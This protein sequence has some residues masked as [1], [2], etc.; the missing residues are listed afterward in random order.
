MQATARSSGTSPLLSPGSHGRSDSLFSIDLRGGPA[1]AGPAAA[2]ATH[3]PARTGQAAPAVA[4]EV[5]IDVPGDAPPPLREQIEAG[6]CRLAFKAPPGPLREAQQ[7]LEHEYVDWAEGV[8]NKRAAAFG[9]GAYSIAQGQRTAFGEAVVPALYDAARQFVSSSSRS[10]VQGATQVGLAPNLRN[11]NGVRVNHGELDSHVDA[12][13]IGGALG[14][15]SAHLID[16]TVLVAMD[17]RAVAA[18]LPQLKPVD[19]KALV[20]DPCPVQL[21]IADGRKEYWRPATEPGGDIEAGEQ[22]SPNRPSMPELRKVAELRRQSLQRIQEGLQANGWGMLAQP[23]VT[24]AFNTLRRVVMPAAALQQ[25]LPVFGSSVLASGAAGGATKLGLGLAKPLARKDVDDLVGGTQR[26]SLFATKLPDPAQPAATLSDIHALPGHLRAGVVDAGR[27]AGHLVVGP[28]RDAGD[29]TA[30]A[31]RNRVFDCAAAVV[32]NTF[33][34]FYAFT[35]GIG[36]ASLARDNSFTPIAGESQKS[37][38][39]LLQQ[40]TSS[41][42]SDLLWQGLKKHLQGKTTDV[43]G[44]YDNHQAR[45]QAVGQHDARSNV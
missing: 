27:L 29:G 17:R 32:S 11:V 44:A 21:R 35:S 41:F 20:P 2:Q 10:P 1:D 28:W 7:A 30:D 6:L 5:R 19:L 18:N 33:A 9:A 8:A 12:A 22:A 4:G 40:A 39:Y 14:G 31:I 45:Y 23:A 38:G 25:A 26:M 34:S 43:A 42:N 37:A 36:M 24:S 15:L 16:S 13:A 3:Q